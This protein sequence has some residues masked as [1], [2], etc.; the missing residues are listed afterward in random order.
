MEKAVIQEHVS[1]F[2][3]CSRMQMFFVFLQC[4]GWF[5]SFFN[6]IWIFPFVKCLYK[7]FTHFLFGCM[8]M[9]FPCGFEVVFFSPSVFR[10]YYQ[11][12]SL[13]IA[14]FFLLNLILLKNGEIFYIP[15]NS[16]ISVVCSSVLYHQH[17]FWNILIA[18]SVS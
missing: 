12:L 2:S 4:F 8:C 10:M 14:L 17:Q 6:V 9:C 16:A 7:C 15:L 13:W 11:P 1:I 3:L 18:L 5:F